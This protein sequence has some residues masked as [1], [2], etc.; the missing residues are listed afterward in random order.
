MTEKQSCVNIVPILLE[1]TNINRYSH[2]Q[3]MWTNA[4]F[5]LLCLIKYYSPCETFPFQTNISVICHG[6]WQRTG[7]STDVSLYVKWHVCSQSIGEGHQKAKIFGDDKFLIMSK[8]EPI[9]KVA[10]R[11][12]VLIND[13]QWSCLCQLSIY[14][15]SH[16]LS[17]YY[18]ILICFQFLSLAGN[19]EVQ[20]KP[21]F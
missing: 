6:L 18:I 15:F 3:W 16:P 10:N 11:K 7:F 12:G 1:Y 17:N 8:F 13:W 5:Q 14:P 21:N 4:G 9:G 20:E 19:T 2:H